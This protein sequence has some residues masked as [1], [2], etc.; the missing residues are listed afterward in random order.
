M[1]N[2]IIV[3]FLLVVTGI[4]ALYALEQFNTPALVQNISVELYGAAVIALITWAIIHPSK[5]KRHA[6]EL[7][8]S[9]V[10]LFHFVVAGPNSV[11]TEIIQHF[12][13]ETETIAKAYVKD[14]KRS[15]AF[16]DYILK[17]SIF[18]KFLGSR[19]HEYIAKSYRENWN[20]TNEPF[21]TLLRTLHGGVFK[22][23][24]KQEQILKITREHVVVP[25]PIP[26]TAAAFASAQIEGIER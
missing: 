18:K 22:E 3:S 25:P 12:I 5:L 14:K 10:Q 2:K 20:A 21:S 11:S 17:L 23:F 15:R 19:N 8:R 9:Y 4:S 6:S 1:A 26:D 16:D 7:H 13:T 24:K